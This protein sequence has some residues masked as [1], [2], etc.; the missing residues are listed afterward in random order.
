VLEALDQM[1][2]HDYFTTDLH[3]EKMTL[4]MELELVY[5]GVSTPSTSR[6]EFSASISARRDRFRIM[7]TR[8]ITSAT[9]PT[10]PNAIPTI[11][12]VLSPP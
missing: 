6:L 4:T 1:T 8:P 5:A 10:P 3:E 9:I 12:P 11:A 7:Q 2:L